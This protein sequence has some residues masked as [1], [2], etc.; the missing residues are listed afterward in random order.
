MHRV[1][2]IC[3]ANICRSPMAMGLLRRRTATQPGQWII[4]SAGTWTEGGEPAALKTM[5][6]LKNRGIDLENFESRILTDELLQ[7]FNLILTM[8]RGHKEAI[9]VEFPE[10]ANR[11]FLLSEMLN[12]DYDIEDPIGKSFS[13]FEE[14][15]K[16]IDEILVKGFRKIYELS[17]G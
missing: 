14:T 3:T 15:A 9:R 16:E 1:L 13:A 4:E 17:E 11:V 12:Q 6:V 7:A 10:L 2:F 8:E 5:Q